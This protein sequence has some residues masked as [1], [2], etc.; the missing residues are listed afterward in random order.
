VKY[1]AE[2]SHARAVLGYAPQVSF[3]DGLRKTIA[4]YRE[5]GLA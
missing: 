3:A 5:R 1:V 2:I 4:W